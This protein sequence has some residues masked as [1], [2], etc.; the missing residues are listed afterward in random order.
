MSGAAVDTPPEVCPRGGCQLIRNH[1]ARE[2]FVHGEVW[3]PI[4]AGD[5][6]YGGKEP[7]LSSGRA[8]RRQVSH[9]DT[10]LTERDR[11]ILAGLEE[12]P[13]DGF[14]CEVCWTTWRSRSSLAAHLRWGHEA[15]APDPEPAEPMRWLAWRVRN[16]QTVSAVIAAERFGATLREASRWMAGGWSRYLGGES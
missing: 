6:I 10:K 12:V 3:S 1:D 7:Q 5:R 13:E 11:R 4:R 9:D 2:C 15:S 14:E 16:G 8:R